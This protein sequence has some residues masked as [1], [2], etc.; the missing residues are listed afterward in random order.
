MQ[1]TFTEVGA[2]RDGPSVDARLGFTGE[3]RLS[4]VLPP[5]VVPHQHDRLAA[6]LGVRVDSEIA[7]QRQCRKGRGPWLT[8]REVAAEVRREA[9]AARPLAVVAAQC[10]QPGA[11]TL[12]RDTGPFGGNLILRRVSQIAQH[13][14]AQRRIRIE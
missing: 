8:G 2:D 9:R 6:L 7:Q 3:E 10:E 1:S 13:L 4:S 12:R 14:P 11:P 5:A